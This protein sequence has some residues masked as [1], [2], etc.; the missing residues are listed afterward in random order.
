MRRRRIDELLQPCRHNSEE[1]G[2]KSMGQRWAT[3]TLDPP[4]GSGNRGGA[5]AC[6]KAPRWVPTRSSL[7]HPRSIWMVVRHE[8]EKGLIASC[9]S[10]ATRSPRKPWEPTVEVAR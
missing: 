5:T 10:F 9:S 3:R 6:L 4:V 2:D 1:A 8:A 7:L